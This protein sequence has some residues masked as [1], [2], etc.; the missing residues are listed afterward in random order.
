MNLGVTVDDA[1][2]HCKASVVRCNVY[3]SIKN[4][5]IIL[6]HS[7]TQDLW[8]QLPIVLIFTTMPYHTAFCN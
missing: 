2:Y 3:L 1:F 6:V 4:E 8:S 5:L 7:L